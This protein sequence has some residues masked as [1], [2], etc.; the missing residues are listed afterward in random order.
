MTTPSPSAPCSRLPSLAPIALE[1][2][3][4]CA[5]R[6][7]IGGMAGFL[8][9]WLKTALALV[10][11]PQLR[12]AL[13]SLGR[14]ARCYAQLQPDERLV[15]LDEM[16][17]TAALVTE[18]LKGEGEKAA[19]GFAWDAPLTALPGIGEARAKNL[20]RLGLHCIGDLLRTCPARYDDRRQFDTVA[21][22]AHRQSA[23]LL[24]EVTG[25]GEVTWQQRRRS[26]K[27]PAA[28]ETGEITLVWF[29]QPYRAGQFSPGTRLVVSGQVRLYR[30]S[31][32]LA[33]SE[34][35][36]VPEDGDAATGLIPVY[37]SAPFSQV[38][39]RRLVRTALDGCTSFPPDPLPE[40]LRCSHDLMSLEKALHE[41]HFPGDE[42]TLAAA[43]RR[44][45]FEELFVMQVRL[46]L[47][48]NKGGAPVPESVVN[49]AEAVL[50]IK[51]L[52]PFPL[53]KAQS[54][55]IEE[56]A[57][58]LREP[59]PANRLVHGDVGSGK[60]VVAAFALLAAV[61]GG[62]QGALM[63]PTEILAQQ[64]HATLAKL[65]E[66]L[67]IRPG[68]LIGSLGE[69]A[70]R[71][72]R[73][74]L[75]DG[76]L[77]LVVGTHALVSDGVDFADL[78]VAIIDEQHRFGV[79]QRARLADK[80]M[81]PNT[82]IMSA[83][84]IPRTLALTA[85]G[86]F[87]VSV[88]DAMPPGRRPVYTELVTRKDAKKAWA[89][90]AEQ[91]C[92]GRQAYVVCPLIEKSDT[93][94]SVAATKLYEHLRQSTLQGFSV[95]LL[96]GKMETQER[97]EIMDRF[98]TGDIEVLVATTVIEVGVDVPNATA[99]VIVDAERFGLAQLHQ[100]RG[101]VAR[102]CDQAYCVLVSSA[103][104]PEVVHR[105]KVLEAV[106][107]GFLVAEEDLK[108]RGPGEMTGLRQSGL[109]DVRLAEMLADTK[110]LVQARKAAFELVAR[111]PALTSLELAPLRDRVG[112]A[113]NWAL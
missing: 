91:V 110:T 5:D 1:R 57:F 98:R 89:L 94:H 43:R 97:E 83:T 74:A 90:V 8:T 13:K 19:P 72:V 22:L 23:C 71:R 87:D 84:P 108:R 105:L 99:M 85:Y 107:D 38:V 7:V 66:P 109:P 80:G 75:A 9:G 88:L 55:V 51:E 20:A 48:R 77:S 10:E 58:D 100:L 73:L 44:L 53:T 30:G 104:S 31:A 113:E 56:I 103:R 95:G 41:V 69:A 65:L 102:S 12:A 62:R 59:Y 79:R 52:V 34:V 45:S 67:G 21:A 6:A 11:D 92:R 68:L 70:G 93:S 15:L 111:D 39:M 29:N 106:Q 78:A 47:R 42:T 101:R 60:T 32:S 4:N 112:R 49:A 28:D 25:P 46:A 33:V 2:R 50:K 37:F 40:A 24:V 63:A 86:E 17:Q 61:Q 96:H 35:E 76:T 64:H 16:E 18:Q 14:R 26:A 81:I 3:H 82:I 54:R 27:V 36:I